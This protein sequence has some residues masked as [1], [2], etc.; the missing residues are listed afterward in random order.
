MHSTIS[1]KQYAQRKGILLGAGVDEDSFQNAKYQAFLIEN[2]NCLYPTCAFKWD[3]IHYEPEKYD[4][5]LA[6]PIVEF[7]VKHDCKL[8]LNCLLWHRDFPDWIKEIKPNEA[9]A[10]EIVTEHFQTILRRYEGIIAYIDVVN[11]AI[12]D[13]GAPRTVGWGKWLGDDWIEFAFRE[14]HKAAP[15]AE[16]FYCD[17]RIKADGKWAAIKALM[18]ELIKRG[19]PIHGL[20]VQLH[21]RLLPALS[22]RQISHHLDKLSDLPLK[23][24][25][26]ECG[27]FT[28]PH[29]GFN[30]LQGT[31]YG[32]MVEAGIL[33]GAQE[34]GFWWP[35][36]W[37]ANPKG[38]MDFMGNPS[39][40]GIYDRNLEEKS[41]TRQV[42][43]A[44]IQTPFPL[45]A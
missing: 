39:S 2:F 10:R 30:Q 9:E 42:R 15:K 8:R 18:L 27:V 21:S 7:A 17:Y 33:A 26:P 35:T 38:W 40:P 44:L 12:D 3:C 11:E 37:R 28:P 4:F 32:G 41:A 45:D 23:L 34:I 22:R 13:N 6:D 43:K 24:H 16:L 1:L 5:R 31:I 29:S 25:L 20:A 19:T 14:A 36:D